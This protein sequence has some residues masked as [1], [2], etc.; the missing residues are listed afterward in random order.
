MKKPLWKSKT[1]WAAVVGVVTAAGGYATG[2]L[3]L[4]EALLALA[5]A[6]GGYGLR[7][8]M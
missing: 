7:D 8:A 3:S 1:V 6:A 5:A 4:V 2:D